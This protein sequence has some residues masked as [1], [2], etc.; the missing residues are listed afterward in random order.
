MAHEHPTTPVD[1]DISP[2]LQRLL[3]TVEKEWEDRK[4]RQR[5]VADADAKRNQTE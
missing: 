4:R 3:H 1:D 2:Y 5:E